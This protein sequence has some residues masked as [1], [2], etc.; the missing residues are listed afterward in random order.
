MDVA[1]V[2]RCAAPNGMCKAESDDQDHNQGRL[3]I[4]QQHRSCHVRTFGRGTRSF[5]EDWDEKRLGMR[6]TQAR[7]IARLDEGKDWA[8]EATF[9]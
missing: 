3:R 7:P 6:R 8:G 9:A 1:D 2:S 5:L 4:P